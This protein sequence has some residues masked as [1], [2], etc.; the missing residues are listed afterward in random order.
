MMSNSL[1]R[2]EQPR[3][4]EEEKSMSLLQGDKEVDGEETPTEESDLPVEDFAEKKK[5]LRFRKRTHF[6]VYRIVKTDIRRQYIT[7]FVN[8]VN[9]QQASLMYSFFHTYASPALICKFNITNKK[10]TIPKSSSRFQGTF[11]F[12]QHF[13]FSIFT[14]GICRIA[15]DYSIRP[16]N[17]IIRTWHQHEEHC[18]LASDLTLQGMFIF[19]IAL[20]YIALIANQTAGNIQLYQVISPTDIHIKDIHNN[21]ILPLDLYMDALDFLALPRHPRKVGKSISNIQLTE[22]VARLII[23][24]NKNRMIEEVLISDPFQ[25]E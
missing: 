20:K 7:M 24:V 17:L 18:E 19:D 14:V 1:L 11:D 25:L 13:A 16:Y 2:V 3:D 4:E 12:V 22:R 9:S 23:K 6:A 8:A 10:K 5:R 21:Q 15:P